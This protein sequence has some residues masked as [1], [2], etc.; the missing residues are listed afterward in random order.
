MLEI[1]L[2]Y[3]SRH[4]AFILHFVLLLYMFYFYYILPLNRRFFP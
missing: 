2:D 1:L 4:D 3:I